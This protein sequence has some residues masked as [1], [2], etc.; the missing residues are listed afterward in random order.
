MPWKGAT[1]VE[2]RFEFVLR[3]RSGGETISDLCWEF[4]ISRKT[5]HKWLKRYE[6]EGSVTALFDHSRRPHQSP[7]KTPREYEERVVELRKLYGWSGRKLK[8]LLKAEGVEISRSTIDRIIDRN[9]LIEKRDRHR[10][11]VKRFERSKPNE[12][13]QMDF[14]GEYILRGVER[15]Y[16][17]SLLDDHSRF[18]VGVFPL[19]AP[20]GE[21]TRRCVVDCFE[22]FGLPDAMLM[23]HGTPWWHS[24]N[25]HGLT[26]FSVGLIKQGIGLIYGSIGHPQ[27]QGKVERFHQTMK[28]SLRHQG[29]PQDFEGMRR[30]LREFRRVYNEVRP[31]Q[32]LD[33]AT[34]ASRYKASNK[35]YD[36]NPR[37]WSYPE[38]ADIRKLNSAGCLDYEGSRSFVSEALACERVWCRRVDNLLVV[39]YRHMYV[40]EIDLSTGRTTAVVRPVETRNL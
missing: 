31:H 27:T 22:E 13:W 26:H 29:V 25:G 8:K 39:R 4:G 30:A 2:R 38:G 1:V 36:P 18:S 16:P 35:A 9:G 11:A 34:P 7:Q 21:Q 33:D 10:P 20:S 32:A 14:K 19:R 24:R 37:E 12:L 3:A 23:D 15:C 17:L 28:R 6:V 40:R 5:G